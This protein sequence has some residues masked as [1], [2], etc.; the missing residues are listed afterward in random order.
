MIANYESLKGNK[1]DAIIEF[2][3]DKKIKEEYKIL[4][5]LAGAILALPHSSCEV[6]RLFSQI[7][8]IKTEKRTNLKEENLE[9]LILL[10][11]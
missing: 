11:A 3:I 10:K 1:Q 6:E 8:L 9:S 5:N 2:Y 7:K 4:S